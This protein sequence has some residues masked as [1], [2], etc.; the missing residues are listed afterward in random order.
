MRLIQF[1]GKTGLGW[2]LVEHYFSYQVEGVD[3]IHHTFKFV[4]Y[5]YRWFSQQL[6]TDRTKPTQRRQARAC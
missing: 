2:W 4:F 3:I 5:W 1:A 6:K